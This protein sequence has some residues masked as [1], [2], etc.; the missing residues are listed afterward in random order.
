LFS[1]KIGETEYSIRAIPLGGFITLIGMY[2]PAKPGKDDSKRWFSQSIISARNA[3][4]EHEQPGDENRKFYQ[5]SAWKRIVVMFGGPFTNLLIGLLLITT[6]ISGLGQSQRINVFANVIDCQSQMLDS[7]AA[8]GPSDV[9][10]P[11]ALAGLKS[12]DKLVSVDGN[13]VTLTEDA[14]LA[15]TELPLVSHR[16]VVKRG[17]QLAEVLIKA[18]QTALPYADASGAIVTNSDGSPK[19]K[20]RPYIGVQWDTRRVAV[21]VETAFGSAVGMTGQTLGLIV[22]FPAQVYNSITSLFGQ[23]ERNPNGAVSIVGVGQAAGAIASNSSASFGDRFLMNL[24][25]IGSLNLA[26]FAFNM[27][28]LPPLDGGHIAGGIYEYI[29]RGLFRL[30]GKKD[31]GIADT[32]LLAPV[33]TGMFLLLLVAGFAMIIVDIVNPLKL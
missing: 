11:A 31:P 17:Q 5:L 26:L 4:S 14:I 3:H 8:C 21:P 18:S 6:A 1:K 33:A 23:H 16:L 10:T 19:L 24:Y 2:P 25:L 27:I 13:Q 12:G 9:H 29:K 20:T 15:V 22:Q 28:P 30:F 7:K 32:A